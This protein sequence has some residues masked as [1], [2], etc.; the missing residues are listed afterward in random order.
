MVSG[1]E[2]LFKGKDG[3]GGGLNTLYGFSQMYD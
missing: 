2:F 1:F 3:G